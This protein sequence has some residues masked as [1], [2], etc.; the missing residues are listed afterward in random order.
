MLTIH[1][2]VLKNEDLQKVIMPK[3]SSILSVQNQFEEICLWASVDTEEEKEERTILIVGTGNPI[4][5]LKSKKE[6]AYFIGTVQLRQGN[7]VFHVFEYR[8]HTK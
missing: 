2:Y 7:L 4:I 5:V 1:K 8:K 6:T 3:N